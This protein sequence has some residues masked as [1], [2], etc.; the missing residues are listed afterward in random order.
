MRRSKSRH[1]RVPFKVKVGPGKARAHPP[2]PSA[3][4]S[5]V[6]GA[7]TATRLSAAGRRLADVRRRAAQHAL[8]ALAPAT[9]RAYAVDWADFETWCRAHRLVA[10]PARPATV[11]LFLTARAPALKLA[12]L[13]RRLAAIVTRHRLIGGHLDCRHPAIRDV[14]AGIRRWRG[15]D[16]SSKQ[17]L[18][19]RE[20]RA[21]LRVAPMGL[22]GARDRALLLIGFAGALR[23]SEIV[24]LDRDALQVSRR[25]VALTIRRSKADPLGTGYIIGI[26]RG[27]NPGTCPVRAL[28]GW[29]A[30][31]AIRRGPVF[32]GIDRHGR[33][34]GRLSD[35]GV[36]RVVKRCAAAA[37]LDAA[38]FSGHSLRSGFATSAAAAGADLAAIMNQTRHR[39]AQTARGYVQRGA[40]FRNRAVRA[41]RL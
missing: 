29:L 19:P 23:R 26:P 39:S 24:A 15:A 36:A 9:R 31:A 28:T 8:N 4:R 1:P 30:A 34:L 11:G 2:R 10:L 17:A 32:R 41:L 7:A 5:S 20:L 38:D 35:K 37:G 3:R 25:G 16:S 13:K 27:R 6:R 40:I 21:L 14:L 12:T 22:R 18:S 33:M